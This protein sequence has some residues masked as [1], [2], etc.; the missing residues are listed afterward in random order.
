MM[1]QIVVREE[2]SHGGGNVQPPFKLSALESSKSRL[3]KGS[4]A[5]ETI[6]RR[7]IIL[8]NKMSCRI[9]LF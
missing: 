1:M 3:C 2:T 6:V 9:L 4:N 8:Q 7:L 5:I